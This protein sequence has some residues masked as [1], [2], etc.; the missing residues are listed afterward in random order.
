MCKLHAQ[1]IHH[2]RT[3]W[4]LDVRAERDRYQICPLSAAPGP[5]VPRIPAAINCPLP[6][7]RPYDRRVPPDD[8]PIKSSIDDFN[9]AAGC[10]L[11]GIAAAVFLAGCGS[12]VITILGGLVL[13]ALHPPANISVAI[14]VVPLILWLPY[15]IVLAMKIGPRGAKLGGM[16][17][18][19][20]YGLPETILEK[21]AEWEEHREQPPEQ[22]PPPEQPPPPPAQ[23]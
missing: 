17:I 18:A 7:R 5:G 2:R 8:D 14:I 22:Q 21:G 20:Q 12:M 4:I 10:G 16:A 13:A 11:V 15:S 9:N 6:W 1:S 23:G 19:A 3:F